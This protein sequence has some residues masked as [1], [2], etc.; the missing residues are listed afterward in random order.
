MKN[1]IITTLL[2]MSLFLQSSN[3]ALAQGLGCG[4]GLGPFAKIFCP[5]GT[6][7]KS[8][9]AAQEAGKQLN[10][11]IGTII[12]VLT[13]VAA[14]WFIFQFIIAGYQWIQSGGEKSNLEQARDKITNSLI[15]LILVV[16]AWIIIGIVGNILDLK[17]LN[18]GQ[19]LLDLAK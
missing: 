14:I 7:I 16:G 10:K 11:L 12:G 8:G 2:V 4:E 18:P 5:S 13:A 6:P 15:G 19:I 17:I 9:D 3:V 1:I